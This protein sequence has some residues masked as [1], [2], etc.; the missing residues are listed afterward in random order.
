VPA[1]I[2]A[3]IPATVTI[4]HLVCRD[5][6]SR[7]R[8][9]KDAAANTRACPDDRVGP[10]YRSYWRKM[11]L[12]FALA[13]RKILMFYTYNILAFTFV[14]ENNSNND[15]NKRVLQSATYHNHYQHHHQSGDTTI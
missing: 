15:D 10:L 1:A 14:F 13:T 11:L 12:Y 9:R 3:I 2:S 6:R 5:C 8:A 7:H 4:T